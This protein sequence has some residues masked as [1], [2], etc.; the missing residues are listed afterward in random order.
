MQ[1]AI[2]ATP[3]ATVEVGG[4]QGI[5]CLMS[6]NLRRDGKTVSSLTFRPSVDGGYRM[7][8]HDV[9][10]KQYALGTMAAMNG[11]NHPDVPMPEDVGVLTQL[12]IDQEKARRKI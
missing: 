9:D 2:P 3:N 11:M 7:V 4:P 6:L 1:A 12:L 8:D 10:T 5:D